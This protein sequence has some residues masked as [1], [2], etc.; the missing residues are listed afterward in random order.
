MTFQID[1]R[2]LPGLRPLQFDFVERTQVL[3]FRVFLRAQVFKEA[4]VPLKEALVQI[5]STPAETLSKVLEFENIL[6]NLNA[7]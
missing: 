7:L 4:V 6:R 5:L 2:L 3:I 1:L